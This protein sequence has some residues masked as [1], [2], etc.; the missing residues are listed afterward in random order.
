MLN[1]L[2]DIFLRALYEPHKYGNNALI[3]EWNAECERIQ[4][5]KD[6][7]VREARE[8]TAS[9]YEPIVYAKWERKENDICY[10][11]E[12]SNCGEEPPHSE[13]GQEYYSPRCP[14]CGAHMSFI[15][16]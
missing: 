6:D 9:G 10:W 4:Q 3:A 8:Q 13:Y 15:E 16:E 11:Y 14:A 2:R 5:I 7:L 1:K 12:C